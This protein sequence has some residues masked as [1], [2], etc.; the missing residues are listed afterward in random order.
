MAGWHGVLTLET[1]I[2]VIIVIHI[3]AIFMVLVYLTG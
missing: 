1:V 3:L 2:K